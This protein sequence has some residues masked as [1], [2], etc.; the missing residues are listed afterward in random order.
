MR[1]SRICF[2]LPAP[3]NPTIREASGESYVNALEA[4]DIVL[5]F[6]D[7]PF[8]NHGAED[9]RTFGRSLRLCPAGNYTAGQL[10]NKA[11]H[12]VGLLNKGNCKHVLWLLWLTYDL[13][14]T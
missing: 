10:K 12:D 13:L 2:R 1:P 14:H 8:L 4:D 11:C 5:S 3:L 7:A 9:F 6:L